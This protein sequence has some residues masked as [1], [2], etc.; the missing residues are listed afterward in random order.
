M[1]ILLSINRALSSSKVT[2]R[3]T[4]P[5]GEK[6]FKEKLCQQAQHIKFRFFLKEKK[7][8]R[9]LKKAWFIVTVYQYIHFFNLSCYVCQ[10]GSFLLHSLSVKARA[11]DLLINPLDPRNAESIRV[12]IAD[13]GN[14]CWVVRQIWLHR[15]R[16]LKYVLKCISNRPQ[17][18]HKGG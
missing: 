18:Q 7:R 4:F 14:A 1:F 12:K 8:E 2:S 13:L 11:A 6:D 5:K 15:K 3:I 10:P 17:D 9:K 16:I